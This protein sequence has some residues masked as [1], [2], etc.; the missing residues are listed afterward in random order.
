[1]TAKFKAWYTGISSLPEIELICHVVHLNVMAIDEDEAQ[2]L[3]YVRW[4]VPCVG[5]TIVGELDIS[6]F[7]VYSTF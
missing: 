6:S 2:Q 3:L 7:H 4:R 1:M 5:L